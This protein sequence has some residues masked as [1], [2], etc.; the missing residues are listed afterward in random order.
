MSY[1]Y[2][3]ART[4][5]FFP[6]QV[7]Y[8]S[9]LGDYASDLAT[10]ERD[11]ARY[12]TLVAAFEKDLASY[13]ATVSSID[14]YY[15]NAARSYNEQ[16][17][18]YQSQYA[19]I[20][21]AN[22]EKARTLAKNYGF[23]LPQS[24]FDNGACISPAQRDAYARNCTTVKGLGRFG[25][26]GSAD[27]DCGMKQL[28]VCNYPVAPVKPVKGAYPKRPTPPVAPTRP[29]PP[30][31]TTP[32]S[33]SGSGS[34]SGGGNNGNSGGG[35]P[36]V[37]TTPLTPVTTTDD[38][39]KKSGMVRNGILLVVVAGGAYLIYRTVKKPKAA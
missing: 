11:W 18:R 20:K 35:N 32:G 17:A 27:P 37:T 4:D 31:T 29:T 26:L 6:P 1:R 36:V 2:L 34:G 24:F 9:G 30:A 38:D 12:L 23:T 28:P 14:T 39:T 13:N 8:L 5:N 19:A 21:S 3:P 33:G 7:P 10:F 15:A 25:G 22:T 16:F